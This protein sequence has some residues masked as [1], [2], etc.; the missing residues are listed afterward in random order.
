MF[1]FMYNSL[2]YAA[3]FNCKSKKLSSIETHICSNSD[4]SRFDDLLN[5]IFKDALRELSETEKQQLMKEQQQWITEVRNKCSQDQFSCLSKAYNLRY[6]ELT[7]IYSEA[8][9]NRMLENDL[10]E[11]SRRGGL[12][13]EETKEVLNNCNETDRNMRIC[14][15]LFSLRIRIAM[16]TALTQKLKISSPDCRS[17]LQ[18]AQKQWEE[19][20]QSQ[21]EKEAQDEFGYGSDAILSY[22]VCMEH[23]IEARTI[24]IPAINS[25]ELP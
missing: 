12:S 9:K 6:S 23:G 5:K 16:D 8:K 13:I 7:N 14:S 22:N 1:A 24:Q 18:A 19:N 17:K 25:C 10:P 4:L 21:C 20:M 3:G 15:N 2:A 11:L